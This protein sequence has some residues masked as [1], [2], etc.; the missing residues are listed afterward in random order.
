MGFSTPQSSRRSARR[1]VPLP[2]DTSAPVEAPQAP[3]IV[4]A[5]LISSG[6]ALK[7]RTW[8]YEYPEPSARPCHSSSQWVGVHG[9]VMI[10]ETSSP[11]SIPP[12]AMASA[13]T[14]GRNFRY[15]W[16]CA[17]IQ[18]KNDE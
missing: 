14:F 11:A 18:G 8:R 12:V 2:Y 6:N 9:S 1:P 13:T 5:A 4:H 10:A 15:G 16:T 7:L 17:S 3:T